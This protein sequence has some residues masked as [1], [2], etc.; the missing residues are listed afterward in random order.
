[1]SQGTTFDL[2]AHWKPTPKNLRI[3]SSK[4][5]NRLRVGGTGSSKSS[6]ALMEALEYML[7]YDGIAVLFI[8]RQLKDLKKSSILDWHTFVPKELYHWNAS[9]H[10]A[11]LK[12]NGSKLFFGHLPNNSEK[13]LEQYLSAAFPVIILDECGQFSGNSVEFLSS[14]NRIN[15][16][17]KPDDTGQMPVPVMLLCTNPI[18]A[19]WPYYHSVFV[20]KRPHDAPE[21]SR[22]DKNGCYWV[23]DSREKSGWRLIYNPA[24]Y[25]YIH[26]T[27]L[28][29]PYLME[30]D[31][32]QYQKLQKLPEPLR[33]KLLSGEMDTTVGQYFD[34]F[35]ES[36]HVIDLAKDPTQII[37]QPWQPRWIG[38]DYGRV[39]YNAM[40][41]FTLALVRTASGEYRE[42]CVCYREY[43]DKG[44]TSR[45]TV[46]NAAA[47]NSAGMPYAKNPKITVSLSTIFFSHEKFSRSQEKKEKLSIAE[48]ISRRLRA[49][50]LPSLTPNDASSGSRIRKAGVMYEKLEADE[51]VILSSCVHLIEAIPQLV[52]DEENQEDVLKV[53]GISKADDCYDAFTMGLYNWSI[54]RVQPAEDAHREAQVLAL[55]KGDYQQAN[56]NQIHFDAQK[57]APFSVTGGRRR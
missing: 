55:E 14:R 48:R 30:R 28:D 13:D 10:I 17:C 31:P 25:D 26:S 32:D 11:T 49:L 4:A 36:R 50:G 29:N 21:D 42:K 53:E 19:Y 20:K 1:M 44:K 6:D 9:D 38:W 57:S 2:A 18:G 34:I 47:M 54:G 39:H 40:Y 15:R 23:P 41:W 27:I 12:H 22:R 45:E 16:E 43:V 8:R 37:W 52:R 24:D 51:V 5:T 33:S 7:R 3:R 46:P 56:W 35:E